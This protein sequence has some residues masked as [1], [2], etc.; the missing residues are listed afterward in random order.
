MG[1]I[2]HWLGGTSGRPAR[3]GRRNMTATTVGM[4]AE[5]VG[6]QPIPSGPRGSPSSTCVITE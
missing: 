3:G 4:L 2:S 6:M 5:L 1:P